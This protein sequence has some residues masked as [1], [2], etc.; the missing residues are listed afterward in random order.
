[1]KVSA[2]AAGS[3]ASGDPPAMPPLLSSQLFS[4]VWQE[5]PSRDPQGD[6]DGWDRTPCRAV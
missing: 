4:T 5:E 6:V 3:A 2:L 1:M